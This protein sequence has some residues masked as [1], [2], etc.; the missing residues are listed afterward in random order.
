MEITDDYD[1]DIL[2]DIEHLDDIYN[3]Y[4]D[5]KEYDKDSYLYFFDKIEF[6]DFY[7]IIRN[8]IDI[9][10]SIEFLEK[11]YNNENSYDMED[12]NNERLD[13]LSRKNLYVKNKKNTKEEYK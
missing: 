9:E 3:I 2:F 1:L 4:Q 7:K 8:N 13:D 5:I 11:I 12:E 10:S 6:V